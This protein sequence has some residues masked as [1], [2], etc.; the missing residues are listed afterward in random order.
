MMAVKDVS[1]PESLSETQSFAAE[2][3]AL[4]S[5]QPESSTMAG[6]LVYCST[7]FHAGE[8][9]DLQFG[10]EHARFLVNWV[11]EAGSEHEGHIGLQSLASGRYIW[12]I[13]LRR[14][15]EHNQK[16]AHPELN[17]SSLRPHKAG[18]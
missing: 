8:I 5:S 11:G 16:Q 6:P 18:G 1:E 14:P 4:P 7:S 17:L 9:V 10:R 2:C 15:E 12:D 3:P 13:T